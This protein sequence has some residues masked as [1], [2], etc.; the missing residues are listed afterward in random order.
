MKKLLLL[1]LLSCLSTPS[2]A[3]VGDVYYCE[4]TKFVTVSED[5]PTTNWKLEKF[6]IKKENDSYGD[7]QVVFYGGYLDD[8]KVPFEKLYGG[9]YSSERVGFF[10]ADN[11]NYHVKYYKG[12]AWVI[13]YGGREVTV[14]IADCL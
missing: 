4:M 5:A 1:L 8:V 12:T 14:I 10:V 13:D 2:L 11:I 6:K 3:E 9:G 7:L